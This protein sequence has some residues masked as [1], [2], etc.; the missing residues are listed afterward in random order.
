MD[1]DW[2]CLRQEFT[3]PQMCPKEKVHKYIVGKSMTFY[4]QSTVHV[5]I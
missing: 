3:D 5:M 4:L 1:S 2:N